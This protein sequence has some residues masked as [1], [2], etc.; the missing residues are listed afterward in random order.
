[1]QENLRKFRSLIVKHLWI[2]VPVFLLLISSSL[3]FATGVWNQGWRVNSNA[4][5]Q[6]ITIDNVNT[7][8]CLTNTSTI[9][10]FVPTN[11]AT[12][13]NEFVAHKP[14]GITIEEC[15][16]NCDSSA[17]LGS[18]DT[19]FTVDA[20]GNSGSIKTGTCASTYCDSLP[21]AICNNGE[22]QL[23]GSNPCRSGVFAWSCTSFPG[24]LGDCSGITNWC[25]GGASGSCTLGD[26]CVIA[27][28]SG[29]GGSGCECGDISSNWVFNG[30]TLDLIPRS[31]V[32]GVTVCP[33]QSYS[34]KDGCGTKNLYDQVPGTTEYACPGNCGGK[35]VAPCNAGGTW[36][37]ISD[38]CH[39]AANCPAGSSFP[40]CSYTAMVSGETK[41]GTCAGAGTCTVSCFDGN[42]QATNNQCGYCG[43]GWCDRDG[44]YGPNEN[45]NCYDCPVCPD[46]CSCTQYGCYNGFN[47]CG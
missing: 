32:G 8:K 12:E 41:A 27:C 40:G 18:G 44:L 3:V 39:Q 38:T 45:C 37:S 9:D 26:S 15:A 47:F 2:I 36:G 24:G 10:Y 7:T 20:G 11:T 22:W 6:P 21:R 17:T 30:S 5:K 42:V 31:C 23:S 1:M 46:G 33:T 34:T 4:D 16:T 28:Q 25:P 13:W 19:S 29:I 14:S 43:D 35:V